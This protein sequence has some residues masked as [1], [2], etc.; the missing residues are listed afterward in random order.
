MSQEDLGHVFRSIGTN[1]SL[2]ERRNMATQII[3][4]IDL[5]IAQ[6]CNLA[7]VYCFCHEGDYKNSGNMTLETA[8]T[9]VDWL[10]NHS[11]GVKNLYI[12]FFGGEPLVNFKVLKQTVQYARKNEHQWNK[13]FSF[14]ITT[15]GVSLTP[16]VELFFDEENI[17]IKA[18]IDGPEDIHNRQR[19]DRGGHGSYDTVMGNFSR[20]LK[21]KPSMIPVSRSVYLQPNTI[22][23]LEIKNF[24]E[25]KGFPYA[26][27][28]TASNTLE[29]RKLEETDNDHSVL[30]SVIDQDAEV[31]TS[32]ITARDSQSLNM[33]KPSLVFQQLMRLIKNQTKIAGCPAGRSYYAVDI[34][35][36]IY[37]CH[38]LVGFDEY[39][40]GNIED[41]GFSQN[42]IYDYGKY[43]EVCQQCEANMLCAG[44]CY[45]ENVLGSKDL[46]E[47]QKHVC[48]YMKY[49]V[50][51]ADNLVASLD[52]ESIEYLHQI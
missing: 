5:L 15:N 13:Q 11:G 21:R 37:L 42:P 32:M 27:L 23:P 33:Y 30:F 17:L 18:S 50:H 22:S 41:E 47:P 6:T 52:A 1:S 19:P 26:S 39:K 8:S 14:T 10:V 48:E 25:G 40:V 4:T 36:D 2:S 34:D 46:F 24:L 7:C 12:N 9:A 20:I 38:S 51:V 44:G 45:F 29:E 49:I 35:G 3:N 28:N 43:P 31:I 16:N